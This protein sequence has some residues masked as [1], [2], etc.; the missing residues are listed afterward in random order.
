LID[1]SVFDLSDVKINSFFFE[2]MNFN[3]K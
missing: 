3:V 1:L 2:G